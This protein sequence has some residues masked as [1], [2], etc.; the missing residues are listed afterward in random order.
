MHCSRKIF[1]FLV[2]VSPTSGIRTEIFLFFFFLFL[3]WLSK[4][5]ITVPHYLQ[6]N[7]DCA[8]KWAMA[9]DSW[10]VIQQHSGRKTRRKR[11]D[12]VFITSFR[13]IRIIAWRIWRK[14]IPW[15]TGKGNLWF[16]LIDSARMIGCASQKIGYEP[17]I[18]HFYWLSSQ[19]IIERLLKARMEFWLTVKQH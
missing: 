4:N 12:S 5:L 10:L 8:M 9:G 17:Y 18:F 15:L 2:F 6:E 13:L 11:E 3:W 1:L 14:R 7:S 19:K 16:D